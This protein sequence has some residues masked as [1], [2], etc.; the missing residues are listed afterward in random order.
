MNMRARRAKKTLELYKK[1]SGGDNKPVDSETLRDFVQDSF[2]LLKAQGHDW[3]DTFDEIVERAYR[4]FPI[5]VKERKND[6]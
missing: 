5:E 2:H 6:R 3:Q 1:L 4:D